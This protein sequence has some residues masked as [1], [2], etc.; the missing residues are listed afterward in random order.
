M[1]GNYCPWPYFQSIKD[2]RNVSFLAAFRAR[3][4]IKRLV[5][6]PMESIYVGVHLWSQAADAAESVAVSDLR[7]SLGDQTYALPDP[8]TIDLHHRHRGARSGRYRSR[9][10]APR[11]SG[12]HV[13]AIAYRRC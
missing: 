2:K 6:D 12:S 4:G 13:L 10:G 11:G 1:A 5:N 7:E 9:R 8:F 3:Y